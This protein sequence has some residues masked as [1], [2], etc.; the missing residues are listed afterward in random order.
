VAGVVLASTGTLLR[1]KL[2]MG[3]SWLLALFAGTCL[4]EMGGYRKSSLGYLSYC[5]SFALSWWALH[6]LT[7]PH[8]IHGAHFLPGIELTEGQAGAILT[9]F[10]G[11]VM[12]YGLYLRGQLDE[13]I[14]RVRTH[15]R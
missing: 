4:G 7:V 15:E 6:D 14:K 5:V 10:G 9:V 11:W 1:V 2:A 13:W 8:A 12:G 3:I